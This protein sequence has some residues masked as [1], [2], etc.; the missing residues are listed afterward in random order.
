MTNLEHPNSKKITIFRAAT[1]LDAAQ[2][3]DVQAYFSYSK[4]SIGAFWESPQS[5]RIGSGLSPTEE[6]LLLPELIE[7]TAED[8][9]FMKKRN[10]FYQD[11]STDVPHA[12]GKTLEIGL[13]TSNKEPIS[14]KN[15]PLNIS[16]YLRYRHAV[17]NPQVALSKED[18]EG[19]SMIEFYIFDKT[20]VNKKS[21]IKADTKDAALQVYLGIKADPTGTKVKQALILLGVNV[22]K[23]D[24]TDMETE[25]RK[26]AETKSDDFLRICETKEFNINYYIKAMIEYK[27]IKQ[28]GQKYFD[29]ETDK[30][31]AKNEEEMVAFFK[32][33]D[34]T[35]LVV[36][37]KARLQ[38]ER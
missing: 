23:L 8:R 35:D 9:E 26:I 19:R 22:A 10:E 16:D 2:N 30:L 3:P 1:F 33:D 36:T 24:P 13:F 12:T 4:R 27:I 34:N 31:L 32:D 11:I 6:R 17:A 29:T 25:L 14:L 38:K 28:L 20:E 37:L 5:Q 7:A 15:M 21:T 18:G